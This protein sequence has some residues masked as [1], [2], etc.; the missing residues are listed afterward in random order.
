M[1]SSQ[2]RL[3]VDLIS[4]TSRLTRIAA[5]ASGNTTPA[6][7]WRILGVLESD[8]PAR[9]GEIAAALRISQPAITQ[10]APTLE[11]QRLVSRAADPH[12]A[13]ATVLTITREGRQALADWRAELA[14]AVAPLLSDLSDDDWAAISRT[15]EILGASA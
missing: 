9:I 7:Q 2:R 3:I 14:G 5:V 12:D 4:A 6:S 8:G 11:E 15:V 10:Y 1:D 13:R